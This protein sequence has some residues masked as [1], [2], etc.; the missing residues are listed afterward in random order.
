[1]VNHDGS[2]GH[3]R[4]AGKRKATRLSWSSPKWSVVLCLRAIGV[5]LSATRFSTSYVR[6]I[7]NK[8][9]IE[10]TRDVSPASVRSARGCGD[11]Q[12]L[13]GSSAPVHLNGEVFGIRQRDRANIDL[14]LWQ[15]SGDGLRGGNFEMWLWLVQTL[16][17]RPTD[18]L[19]TGTEAPDERP[20]GEE[21][22]PAE[23]RR[24]QPAP[25][26]RRRKS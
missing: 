15:G 25:I 1:M 14:D 7:L 24:A 9:L 5:A 21:P 23:P 18:R 20:P 10:A 17:R 26:R 13:A 6:I 4:S 12:P 11:D 2:L 3:L 8:E 22:A 16:V 19:R